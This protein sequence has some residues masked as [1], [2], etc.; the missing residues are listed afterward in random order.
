MEIGHADS[1]ES[2]LGWEDLDEIFVRFLPKEELS[3]VRNAVR[4]LMCGGGTEFWKVRDV[5][6][7]MYNQTGLL[8]ILDQWKEQC[9]QSGQQILLLCVDVAKLVNINQ[10][11]GHSEGDVAIQTLARM[12]EDGLDEGE[13]CGRFG[14]GEFV[15]AMRTSG[16]ETKRANSF[17]SVID[18]SLDTYNRVSGKEYSLHI[19]HSMS[20]VS[21]EEDT[22]MQTVLD[23]ALSQKRRQGNGRML[24]SID[25][26]DWEIDPAEHLLVQ[27]IMDKNRFRYAFQPII[28]AKNGE[29][30]A[31]E[32]LMRTEQSVSV[33]PAVILKYAGLD[34]RLYDIEKATFFNVFQRIKD[35]EL[36]DR[37]IF[38]NSIPGYQLRDED[39]DELRK[40]YGELFPHVVVEITEQTEMTDGDMDIL[41]R[42]GEADGFGV[43]IDDYGT[44]YSNTAS[45]LRFLPNCVKIDRLLITD[46]QENPKKQHFVNNIVEFAHENGILALAEGVETAAELKAVIQM[47][48]D[49]IQGFYTAR[50]DYE[51]LAELDRE[52][53]DEI[54]SDNISLHD[55]IQRKIY[56]VS[57]E[58]ELPL[59]RLALEQ[60]TGIVV[61]QPELTLVGNPDYLAGMTI[62]IKDGCS[63]RVTLRDVWL[64]SVKDMPCIDVGAGA[65]LTLVLEG[66]N[67]L[68]KVGIRVPDQSSCRIEGSG[69]LVIH[70][71]GIHGYGIGNDCNSGVGAIVWASSGLLSVGTDGNKCICIGG[72]IYRQ[73]EG[74]RI[75]AGRVELGVTGVEVVGIGCVEGAMPIEIHDCSLN[76]DFRVA[77][78]NAVGS[79]KGDQRIQISNVRLKING[80]G[81][82]LCGVGSIERTA[83][84]ID[85]QTS[86]IGLHMTGQ[87]VWLI[88]NAGGELTVTAGKS[89]VQL[90]GEGNNLLGIG[91][92]DSSA[93][94]ELTYVTMEI[95]L[96]AA[97][98]IGIGAL[99]D[100][101]KFE[102][103]ERKVWINEDH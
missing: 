99:Q 69:D 95:D 14:S 94:L 84:R 85:I 42:R 25:E 1:R 2:V 26:T 10:I 79:W 29:I 65:Q 33:S 16:E 67:T 103:G 6:T 98:P 7:G 5:M 35:E 86:E 19:T 39:Y 55:H 54:I 89:N 51:L 77:T 91:S 102:G 73:G 23:S 48:V 45:L 3:K 58:R 76:M 43:A 61:S 56:I 70:A 81:S 49:L 71:K 46:I 47:G 101:C 60:Y 100:A 93:K 8:Q 72:G 36:K 28:D 92:Y 83:G 34:N 59:M 75:L 64:E 38:L 13:V 88:G 9:L 44:G 27:E 82:Q 97:E 40:H 57:G 21:V 68:E 12:L 66:G 17:F 90:I 74:I 50:P 62:K 15:I 78:G 31:Y 18:K 32:A 22:Q 37:K 30:Y 80:S 41:L 20:T 52:R 63:C 11:Y 4:E 96:R 24:G 87:K 53:R